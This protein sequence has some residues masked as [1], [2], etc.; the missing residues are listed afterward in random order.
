MV[1][2]PARRFRRGSQGEDEGLT[3]HV[4]REGHVL[5]DRTGN[6]DQWWR[7]VL[8][9]LLIGRIQGFMMLATSRV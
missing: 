9:K 5:R 3:M 6:V 4:M 8:G 2:I 1:A 7:Y